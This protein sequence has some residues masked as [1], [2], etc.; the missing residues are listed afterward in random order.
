MQLASALLRRELRRNRGL[1]QGEGTVI[2]SLG[3]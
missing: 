1:R 3:V 2:T